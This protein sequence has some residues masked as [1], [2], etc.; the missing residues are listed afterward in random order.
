MLAGCTGIVSNQKRLTLT[1]ESAGP[2]T[3]GQTRQDVLGYRTEYKFHDVLQPGEGESAFPVIEVFQDDQLLLVLELHENLVD[4]IRVVGDRIR[5]PDGIGVGSTL[6]ELRK[7]F[8]RAPE[9]LYGEDGFFAV[10]ETERGTLSFGLDVPVEGVS[11]SVTDQTRVSF[12]L[13]TKDN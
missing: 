13:I 12:I 11:R 6:N 1:E 9:I 7:H 2:F 3:I 10:F 5:T 8:G 4:R